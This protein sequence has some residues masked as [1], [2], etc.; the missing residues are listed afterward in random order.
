MTSAG[1]VMGW[2]SGVRKGRKPCSLPGSWVDGGLLSEM[3]GALKE[4]QI[5][6]RKSRTVV[7]GQYGF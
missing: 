1:L 7:W 4:E 5:Q 6:D 3:R 2:M